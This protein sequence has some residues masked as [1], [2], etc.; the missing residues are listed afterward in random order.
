MTDLAGERYVSL[1]TF[2]RDGTTASTPV[3]VV[4]DGEQLLVWTGANTWKVKRIRN[5]QRVR[6][7]PSN[8][9]GKLRGTTI[10][11]LATIVA[12]TSHV[13]VLLAR[14]YGLMYRA[15]RGFNTLM[16]WVQRKPAAQSVTLAITDR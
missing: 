5:D 13:E 1:T 12:D 10:D 8:A 2:K 15:L 7:T 14:K 16:R 4:G 9:S 11:G 6:V 3:W